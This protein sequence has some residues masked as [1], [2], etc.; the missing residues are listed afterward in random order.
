MFLFKWKR[1]YYKAL[2][3]SIADP[4]QSIEEFLQILRTGPQNKTKSKE[5]IL[6]KFLNNSTHC[7]YLYEKIK[8]LH[9]KMSL[10]D[11]YSIILIN[12]V[13]I[14]MHLRLKV[15]LLNDK[16]AKETKE[17]LNRLDTLMSYMPQ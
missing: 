5:K 3:E 17:I 1:K 7:K 9:D 14:P 11:K 6:K 10:I 16:Y 8:V 2:S 13:N 12:S 4:N 15:Q